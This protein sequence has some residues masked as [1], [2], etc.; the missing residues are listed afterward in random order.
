MSKK[1][2][3]NVKKV[4]NYQ[5]ML[6]V[7][8]IAL[9]IYFCIQEPVFAKPKVMLNVIEII[10]ETLIM[11]LP[12]TFIIT[13]GGIDLSVG[14]NLTMSA[15]LFGLT[16]NETGNIFLAIA[17]CIIIGT[18]GGALNGAIIAFTRIPPLVC[19]LATMSLYRG[20]ALIVAGSNTF[21]GFPEAFK[22]MSKIRFGGVMPIQITYLAVLF[23]IFVVLYNRSSLGRY[24]RGIG[25]N[26]DAVIYSGISTPKIKFWIYTVCGT[27]CGFAALVYLGRLSAAKPSMGADMNLEVITA[28]VLGGTS[29][30]GGV[31]SVTGTMIGALIIGV[32]KKGFTIMNLSGNIYNFVI[33]A[34]LIVGL[35]VFAVIEER[36]KTVKHKHR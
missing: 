30:L 18:A 34:I 29:T 1:P 28:V 2:L 36:K 19:T 12:M 24:L 3:L 32:L 31:G 13:T 14:F 35:I 6:F 17:V 20:I 10:G 23:L 9:I 7:L 16:F 26:E 22:A 8:L 27:L 33:G 5:S 21:T 15:I 25:F 4:V 11:A